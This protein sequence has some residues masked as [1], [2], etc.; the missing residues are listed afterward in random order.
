M[1]RIG[2]IAIKKIRK[3]SEE[4]NLQQRKILVLVALFTLGRLSICVIY[5]LG[6]AFLKR[7]WKLKDDVIILFH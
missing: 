5:R 3:I 1:S 2:Y 7:L 4:I 6:I